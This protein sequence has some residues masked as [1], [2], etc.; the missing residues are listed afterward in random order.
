MIIGVVGYLGS[1]PRLTAPYISGLVSRYLLRIEQ[2]GIRVDNFSVRP[3]EGVDLYSVSLTLPGENGGMTLVSVDTVIVDF[4]LTKALGAVP[5]LSRVTVRRPEVYSMASGDTV[6]R[7][8]RHGPLLP[9]L[10]IDQMIVSDAFLEF[11]GADGRLVERISRLD[12]SGSVDSG[13]V[14]RM[15]LRGVDVDWETHDSQLTQ[16]RGEVV[17]DRQGVSVKEVTGRLNDHFVRVSGFRDWDTEM[18]I[19]VEATGVSTGEVENLINQNLGFAAAGDLVGMFAIVNDT[20]HYEGVFTGEVEGYKA[21][22]LRGKAVVG[23]DTVELTDL[24]GDINGAG[25]V[26]E[27]HFDISDPENVSFE[28]YGDVQNVDVSRGLVPGEEG[29]PVTDGRGRLSIE[30]TDNP[31]WTRVSGVLY[32]GAIDM[33]PFDTCFVDIEAFTD[34]V[35]FNNME[36]FYG[37]IH[38]L[39]EGFS[40]SSQVFTGDLS[41]NSE[42]L[43]SLPDD[44]NWPT[45]FGRL[46]GQGQLHGPLDNLDFVGDL[47]LFDFQ[48]DSVSASDSGVGL[49][50]NNV[51]V[52]P[53]FAFDI[54]GQDLVAGGVE[55][56]DFQLVG[57]ISS[58]GAQVDTFAAALGDTALLLR[59]D[60][61]FSDS[62]IAFDVAEFS[63]DMEGTNWSLANPFTLGVGDGH[64]ALNDLQL[65]SS[66][67]ELSG[68]GLFV[69]DQQVNGSLHF[70]NFDLGL[71]NPFVETQAPLAGGLTAEVTA[72][73][74]PSAPTLHM[75]GTM[76]GGDFAMAQ[77]DSLEVAAQYQAGTVTMHRLGL[78]TEFGRFRINGQ[79]SNPGAAI[80]DY[81]H[82]ADL[83][84]DVV[85]EE[86]DW[87]ALDQFAMPA[88]DRLEGDFT[89]DIRVSG[90]TLEPVIRGQMHSAPFHVH[91]LHL[92]DLSAEIEADSRGLVLGNLKGR[93]GELNLSGRIEIPLE[94]DL[95]SEPIAPLDGPFYM[96]LEI[97][98]GTDLTALSQA[99]NAFV[100]SSG[101]G[102]ASVVVAGPLDH[103][104]WQGDLKLSDVSFVMRD[105]EE[106]YQEAS[107]EGTFAR[108]KLLLT[109]LQGKEGLRGRFNGAGSV[110]FRGL[111]VESFDLRLDLD[112]FLLASIPDL[113][114]VASSRNAR[115]TGMMVG[116]DSVLVPKFH[117]DFE[118]H[119]AR[120]TGS[121]EEKEGSNDPLLGTVAPDWLA[122]LTLHADPRVAHIMNR[123]M[124]LL[125]GGDLNL[126]R[127]MGGL[128]MR[129]SM[130]VNTGEL[131]VFNNKFRVQSGRLD[132]SRA[133]G[134]DPRIDL[135]A[136]IEYRLRFAGSSNSVIE[137][138]GVHVSGL[139]S[140]PTVRFSSER[141]Y[142]E[143]AI[144]R[145]LLGLEPHATPEG[146]S[147]RLTNS[148][149][150]AGFNLIEREIAR[151]VDIVDTI[152]IDQIQRQRTTGD[153]GL[154]P[155]IGVGKYI[156]QD[157]YLKYA[158]GISGVDDLDIVVEYQINR[159][160]LL[161]SEMRRRLDENQ[162]ESTYNLDLKYRFEY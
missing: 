156:G 43:T 58:A 74:D 35:I 83:E 19:E 5:H 157:L 102:E 73:G 26:G 144:Q 151:E 94:M 148:S 24:E 147:Q 39:L 82:D 2:G 75:T 46:N 12:W 15:N 78:K 13:D 117:G 96:Q 16:L 136:G 86:M 131:I 42:D 129:G 108:D 65:N 25:F 14:V 155:L 63:V 31:L 47:R 130:D 7:K 123:E 89:G 60:A 38:A 110:T 97:P 143:N 37:D 9:R 45:L 87:A 40:D 77:V 52:D 109:N 10:K 114:A 6:A 48:L 30:H 101:I 149:I 62:V 122:D 124:D 158:Q 22:D 152:E 95:I 92:D 141:G 76:V 68:E 90:S 20:L 104:F 128:S 57:K 112:R 36:L 80:I 28:L 99:T 120:Y 100:E 142:S 127:T 66:R 49:V 116:P 126:V 91:W 11:S 85:F 53:R 79:I 150:S 72:D 55:V 51:L 56:G 119:K 106:V 88:L 159:H 18:R 81:W 34:T 137:H 29:M 93:K 118:V 140:N 64:F 113:R 154:D 33:V 139:M 115:M 161:Q 121:F 107:V 1:H 133:V 4:A 134:F 105:L 132:F 21:T 98:P 84:L 23:G 111:M 138:I 27:G 71:L 61:A 50:V 59:F 32:D 162:G 17:V 125:L 70:R 41:V 8:K 54:D 145:M 3:F 67:G 103:P 160:L 69:R 44:W 146:D 135:D 153:T